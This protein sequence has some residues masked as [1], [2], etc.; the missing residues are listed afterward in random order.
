MGL[1]PQPD[2]YGIYT[3]GFSD[4]EVMRIYSGHCYNPEIPRWFIIIPIESRSVE[5]VSSDTPL[6]GGVV[7]QKQFRVLHW[8]SSTNRISP[9]DLSS[10][11]HSLVFAR[12]LPVSSCC[13]LACEAVLTRKSSLFVNTS[14]SRSEDVPQQQMLCFPDIKFLTPL[15]DQGLSS[16]C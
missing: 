1:S 8:G 11:G 9:I 13:F 16:F 14:L 5:T 15:T 2:G 7:C 3:M 4:G 6:P 12:G 10:M